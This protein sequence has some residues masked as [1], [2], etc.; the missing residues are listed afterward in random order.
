[1][2]VIFPEF[3]LYGFDLVASD[4]VG[5]VE[6]IVDGGERNIC[7]VVKVDVDANICGERTHL[8]HARPVLVGVE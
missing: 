3:K 1:M 2:A 5:Q 7:I 8:G 6:E 4:Y